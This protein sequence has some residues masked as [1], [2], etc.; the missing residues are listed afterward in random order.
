ML[1][2]TTSVS[3]CLKIYEDQLLDYNFNIKISDILIK[4]FTY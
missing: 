4:E 2:L 3:G 1:L